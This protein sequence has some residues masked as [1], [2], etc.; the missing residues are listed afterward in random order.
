M[1]GVADHGAFHRIDFFD[2]NVHRLDLACPDPQEAAQRA[3][4]D[5]VKSQLREVWLQTPA[6]REAGQ[7]AQRLLQSNF[8]DAYWTLARLVARLLAR[9]VAHHT[10]NGCK[11]QPGDL[12]GIGTNSGPPPGQGAWLRD[13]SQGGKTPLAL[14]NGVTRSF[15]QDRDRVTLRAFRERNGARRIGFGDFAGSLLAARSPA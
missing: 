15:L 9:L 1:L 14:A 6:R 3:L 13:L 11:L 10:V 5:A 8:R 4:L 2:P 7:P 12:L